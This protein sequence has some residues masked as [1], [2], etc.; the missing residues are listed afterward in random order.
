MNILKLK[1]LLFNVAK[2]NNQILKVSQ[3]QKD[4]ENRIFTAFIYYIVFV[5][6]E[7]SEKQKLRFTT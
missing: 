5:I 3:R 6:L 7:K 1:Q 4:S 2:K